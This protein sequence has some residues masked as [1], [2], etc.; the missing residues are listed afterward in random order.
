[1]S[2]AHSSV[3]ET[4]S[5]R[6]H[7]RRPRVRDR[8]RT[9]GHA[10]YPAGRAHQRRPSRQRTRIR[11]DAGAGSAQTPRAGTSRRRLPASWHIR[12][13]G[14]HDRSRR[15]LRDP[16]ATR[17]DRGG[18]GG[19]DRVRRRAGPA[20]GAGR[21][22]RRRSTTAKT[23][24]KSCA[25]TC[26][27]TARST[28]HR[29][30]SLPRG[31]PRQPRRTRHPNLVSLPGPAA[32]RREHVQEHVALLQAI[33]AGDEERPPRPDPRRTSRVSSRPS[34][35]CCRPPAVRLSGSGSYQKGAR[36]RAPQ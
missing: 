36:A 17:A 30:Q 3:A 6:R 19:P 7:Q 33:V 4:A 24:A 20:D 10:G 21:G 34:A 14:R 25:R 22:D 5:T 29:G 13:R 23:R 16:Q 2:L 11:P 28:A 15:H 31:H 18:P 27:F 35:T 8:P 26:A 32:R 1:M 9:A 12:D